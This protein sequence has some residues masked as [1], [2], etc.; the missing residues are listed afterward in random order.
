MAASA[1]NEEPARQTECSPTNQKAFQQTTIEVE[2]A[3]VRPFHQVEREQHQQHQQE[4]YD[5]PTA[6]KKA[7][8]TLDDE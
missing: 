2:A 6:A 5:A 8:H 7:R 1:E 4:A 3:G